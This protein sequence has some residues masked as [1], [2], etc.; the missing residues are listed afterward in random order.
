MPKLETR[1]CNDCNLAYDVMCWP[2][3]DIEM[4]QDFDY[5]NIDEA[6]VVGVTAPCPG[7][8]STKST[9]NLPM[10]ALH[11]DLDFPRYNSGLGMV[12]RSQAHH[13]A[14]CKERNLVRCTD[15]DVEF[16]CGEAARH[17][18]A[19][20]Q[21][22]QEWKDLQA[23]YD[24]DPECRRALDIAVQ[25]KESGDGFQAAQ[26]GGGYEPERNIADTA[27]DIGYTD[28]EIAEAARAELG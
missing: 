20:L 2:S 4:L 5:R 17:D 28:A 3:D 6:K 16:L 22:I 24:D 26:G 10:P 25:M 8:R 18:T 1:T 11:V 27:R 14:V 19:N 23:Y 15:S 9:V 7:C 12:V 21:A 13:D